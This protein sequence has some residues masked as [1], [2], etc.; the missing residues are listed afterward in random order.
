MIQ[1]QLF[2]HPKRELYL[3][4]SEVEKKSLRLLVQCLHHLWISHYI[5]YLLPTQH[6][7]SIKAYPF[8]LEV[9]TS[10]DLQNS[11]FLYSEWVVPNPAAAPG[12]SCRPTPVWQVGR[13]Y[14]RI[15]G[16]FFKDA[17]LTS[18]KYYPFMVFK[19]CKILLVYVTEI[20]GMVKWQLETQD[21]SRVRTNVRQN[22]EGGMKKDRAS[23][24]SGIE[25]QK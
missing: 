16:F 23:G 14:Y 21:R 4:V 15:K 11:L 18:M 3:I 13:E 17:Y 20:R 19:A 5:K 2:V 1:V 22:R 12:P 8:I 24:G 25:K 9:A 7:A 6:R 10:S